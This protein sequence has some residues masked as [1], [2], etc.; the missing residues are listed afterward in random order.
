MLQGHGATELGLAGTVMISR[1]HLS[2]GTDHPKLMSGG[3][4]PLCGDARD[5]RLLA[6]LRRST[7]LHLCLFWPEASNQVG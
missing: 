3:Y 4:R 5:V 6:T 7:P 1:F 2:T